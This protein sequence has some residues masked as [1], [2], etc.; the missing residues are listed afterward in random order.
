MSN[1]L[2]VACMVIV[3]IAIVPALAAARP[4]ITYPTGTITPTG[5]KIEATN[6]DR[7]VMSFQDG[8]SLEC[9]S[10]LLTGTL[11]RNDT[12]RGF[13]GEIERAEFGGT[14]PV[15]GDWPQMECTG[16]LKPSAVK[17]TS[18]P[19]CLEGIEASG[20]FQLKGG[21]CDAPTASVTFDLA[22]TSAFGPINCKY[23]RAT[24]IPGTF[25]TDTTGQDITASISKAPFTRD[26]SSVIC[27]DEGKLT[28]T[29]T[30]G[31]DAVSSTEPVYV[32]P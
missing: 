31:T 20:N 30:I 14:G 12:P 27:P 17:V 3:K 5:T 6:V 16:G 18:L 8:S 7:T 29:F 23:K 24:K 32:S 9:T 4:V 21:K 10:A 2:I 26:E 19:W 1:R 13:E 25:Q 11:T 28:M 22:M 15:V